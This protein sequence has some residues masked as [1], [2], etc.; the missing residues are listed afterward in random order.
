[1]NREISPLSKWNGGD[2]M[3]SLKS[4]DIVFDTVRFA[5]PVRH[6]MLVNLTRRL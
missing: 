6:M 1:M 4:D 3:L 2:I 5:L